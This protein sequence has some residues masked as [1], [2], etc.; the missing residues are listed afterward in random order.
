MDTIT[1]LPSFS[2]RGRSCAFM[3]PAAK[4]P[5]G[6]AAITTSE[7]QVGPVVFRLDLCAT[8]ADQA[9]RVLMAVGS[10]PSVS[11]PRAPRRVRRT[12]SGRAFDA[13]DVRAW[14]AEKGEHVNSRGR[15]P[16]CELAAYAEAH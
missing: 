13:S 9:A 4:A 15:L 7:T 12:A 3:A 11:R 10:R 6:L 1:A 16:E 2:S 8:H 5:C 14:L